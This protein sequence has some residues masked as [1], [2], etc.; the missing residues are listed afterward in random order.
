MTVEEA[1][2]RAKAHQQAGRWQDA[3]AAYEEVASAVPGLAQVH[4]IRGL[5]LQNL[6]R[7]EES[8]AVLTHATTA[9]PDLA[10][11]WNDRGNALY[12]L[13]RMDDAEES[14]RRAVALKP[15]SAPFH[16]NR[17]AALLALSRAQDALTTF[18]TA[19]NLD[20][21]FPEAHN[22]R[23]NALKDLG[24]NETAALAY[25]HALAIRPENPEAL[26]NHGNVLIRLNR[27][28]EAIAA[29]SRAVELAPDFPFAKGYL[30]HAKMLACDWRG[31]EALRDDVESRVDAGQACAEPFGHQGISESSRVLCRCAEIFAAARYPSQSMVLAKPP[32]HRRIRVGYLSGEFRNQATSILMAE[33]FE[34]HDRDH[35][36]ILAL[37]NGWDDASDL[38]VRLVKAFDQVI[39]ISR[40]SDPAAAAMIAERRIDILVNLN[41]YFGAGRQ[42]VFSRKPAPVQVNYLGFPGTLG[43]TYMDYM[44]ADRIVIPE[45][46]RLHYV[47]KIAYL[48]GTYQPNDRL[49]RI[50]DKE[51]S[52]AE[53]GLPETGIVFCCFNNNYK[54]TPWMFDI[55]MRLLLKIPGSSLWLLQDN[56]TAAAN[57]RAE[58]RTR[59]VSPERLVFADRIGHAEHLARHRAADLFLDTL[60]YNA[61]TTASDALWAGLPVLT[62]LGSTFPSRVGASL[63]QA[64]GLPELVTTNLAEYEAAALR[65]AQSPALISDLKRRLAEARSTAPLFDATRTTRDLERL[66]TIMHTRARSGLPPEH[67]DET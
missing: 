30:L 63:L 9:Q 18:D 14:Y 32:D 11:A 64:V 22:N 23:G 10:E 26:V 27:N 45:S 7:I 39:D 57:L 52:R 3:L 44:I 20:P 65:L 67:I 4:H 48:P 61:H 41:G 25:A 49:R 31:L 1:L 6:G 36:E 50:T 21:N 47:E 58:A 38:R 53:L 37:D 62:C 56:D 43:A 33:V 5:I 34:R 35:F 29:L 13:K 8:L 12:R 42:G 55:W 15:D 16:N 2:C 51:F 24:Q 60:P 28:V 17:G 59:G 46:D 66:F 19:I 54:I 40:L